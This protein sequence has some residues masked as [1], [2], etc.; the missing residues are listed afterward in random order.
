MEQSL[1]KP[2]RPSIRNLSDEPLPSKASIQVGHG[3]V[4]FGYSW[5]TEQL[6]QFSL[7]GFSRVSLNLGFGEPR[8]CTTDSRGSRHIRGFRDFRYSSNRSPCLWKYDQRC[9]Y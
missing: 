2:S 3:S 1:A 8:F 5:G 4:P 6:E 9:V 7:D